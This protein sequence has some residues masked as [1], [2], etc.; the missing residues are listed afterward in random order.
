[1]WCRPLT[2]LPQSGWNVCAQNAWN[3]ESRCQTAWINSL[4]D[5]CIWGPPEG[6]DIG[7]TERVA[8][9]FC[10]TDKHGTRLIPDGTIT[11]AHFVQTSS[12]GE[13]PATRGVVCRHHADT[14]TVQITGTGDFTKIGLPAGDQGGEMDSHGA[15]D[16]S[17]P[18]GGVVYTTANPATNGQP[19]FVS[20]WTNFMSHN[21]Y[22]MRACWGN[23]ARERCQ[24]IYDGTSDA[25]WMA[26]GV[27]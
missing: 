27:D 9:A 10:T 5:W 13:P 6:G 26:W 23:D 19:F 3:Q 21:Q 16:L 11:G 25:W 24:H 2:T 18:V 17:N 1:M 20:E 4:E 14:S 7:S 8:V 22:C 12:Y 15:D